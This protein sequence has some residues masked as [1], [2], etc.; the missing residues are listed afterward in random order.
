MN[1][2]TYRVPTNVIFGR[3][4]E[5]RVGA[6]IKSLSGTTV[7]VLYGGGSVI[8]NGLLERVTASLTGEGLTVYS[9]GG[10]K[11]NPL[12]ELAQQMVETYKDKKIDFVLGVGGG[13]VLDTA[14]AVAIGLVRPETPIWDYY[15]RKAEVTDALPVGA[16]LTI[17]AAGSE[18]S[19]SAVLTLE[20]TGEKRGVNTPFNRP[21]FAILNPE[22]TYTLPSRQTAC[23]V[24]D[25]M[26]HTLDR[27]FSTETDNAITDGIAEAILR[28]TVTYGTIA[29]EAPRDYKSRSEL[30]WC[31]SLSHNGL[32]G[33]GQP[34]DFS[35]HALG[36]EL[37]G[38]FDIPHGESLSI[39]WPAWARFSWQTSPARFAQYGRNV[40]GIC[41][42]DDRV[43]A[44]AAIDATEEYFK[45][46]GMPVCFGQAEMGIQEERVIHSLARRCS[47]DGG[48]VVGQFSPLKEDELYKIYMDA[49]Q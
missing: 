27:Y 37:S 8:K 39:M 2:F 16:V 13:S 6:E 28:T 42:K 35:V 23:G 32:T 14:K 43:C 20:A 44:Q 12:L 38:M 47:F 9:V 21:A 41:E 31:G 48:R 25:I 3:E 11:P 24:V 46:L 10:I 1:D 30:M 34:R 22:L 5:N 19:D 29:M 7:L 33:L 49:N 36:H 17:A 40:W 45:S 18:T 4:T 15:L 26:M